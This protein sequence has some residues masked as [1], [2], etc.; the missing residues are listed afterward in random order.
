[1]TVGKFLSNLLDSL[2]KNFIKFVVGVL[3]LIVAGLGYSWH[4][5]NIELKK[6]KT[7]LIGQKNAY[8]QVSDKLAKLGTEYV[9][10]KELAERA[11][12]KWK[13]ELATNKQLRDH[14]R[15]LVTATFSVTQPPQVGPPDVLVPGPD[16]YLYHEIAY[17]QSSGKQGPPLGYVRVQNETGV[18][19][20]KVFNHEIVVDSAIS[21]EDKSG[22][23]SV[24]S[25][26]FYVLRE[27]TLADSDPSS[28]KTSWVDVYYPLA[29]T[30]GT[31]VFTP[32][33]PPLPPTLPNRFQ[34]ALHL[35]VGVFGGVNAAGFDWGA[36]VDVTFAGYGRSRNDLDYKILGVGANA[37]RGY[38]DLNAVPVQ[39][40]MSFLP[41][42]SDVWI[43][44]G[45][46]FGNR[47]TNYFLTIGGTL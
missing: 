18:V 16:G 20:S 45:V 11:E 6:A 31:L 19:A 32:A 15:G 44:P 33:A 37:N 39:W 24:F 1:M 42:V 25:K 36:H 47:G 26:G 38:V 12:E 43:G 41:L 9:S 46:G 13:R 14:L 4:Q 17:V 21:V 3:L 29:I 28:G 23:I 35:N 8:Q 2:L 34:K 7:D 22:K 10:A 30:G 5:Q 40:R 27:P